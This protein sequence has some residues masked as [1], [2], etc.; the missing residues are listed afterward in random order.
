MKLYHF[1]EL[2][3]GSVGKTTLGT[4]FSSDEHR[5]SFGLIYVLRHENLYKIGYTM[6]EKQLDNRIKTARRQFG[7]PFDLYH[8]MVTNCMKAAER[9]IHK[10]FY[11]H[12]LFRLPESAYTT[13]IFM[14]SDIDARSLKFVEECDFRIEHPFGSI[15]KHI[16]NDSSALYLGV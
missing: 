5:C 16:P 15:Y 4:T 3:D 6:S 8:V 2:E 11:Q 12:R 7:Y 14:L 10:R 1:N 13:E 9:L